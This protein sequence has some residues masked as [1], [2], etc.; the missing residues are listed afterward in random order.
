MRLSK[1][2]P[3][4]KMEHGMLGQNGIMGEMVFHFASKPSPVLPHAHFTYENS[5]KKMYKRL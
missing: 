1:R 2:N 4:G 3:G 5:V